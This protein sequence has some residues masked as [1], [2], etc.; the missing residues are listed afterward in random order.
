MISLDFCHNNGLKK[1]EDSRAFQNGTFRT[2]SMISL[3]DI[4]PK[5]TNRLSSQNDIRPDLNSERSGTDP[6]S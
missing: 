6:N 3:V 1:I 5:I 4:N 2:V